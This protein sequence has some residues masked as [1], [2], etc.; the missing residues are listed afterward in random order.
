MRNESS[1][2]VQHPYGGSAALHPNCFATSP[3]YY[4]MVNFTERD[5]V[6]NWEKAFENI[7]VSN[8]GG[9][10]GKAACKN[11]FRLGVHETEQ[12]SAKQTTTG[13][14]V[15]LPLCPY[16]SH[17]NPEPQCDVFTEIGGNFY[18]ERANGICD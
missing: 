8:G 9:E 14:N 5:S 16:V 13:K 10:C 6:E 1:H 17:I 2:S 7:W 11:Y 4:V 18:C 3:Y 15:E 12:L